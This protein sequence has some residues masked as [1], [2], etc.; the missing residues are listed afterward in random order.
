MNLAV[1]GHVEWV[2]FVRVARVPLPGEIVHAVE[3]W[4]EAAGGG[5]IA[6]VQLAKLNGSAH[7]FTS[8]GDDELGRRSRSELEERGVTLHAAAAAVPQRR[9]FTYVDERGERTITV[10]GPKLLPSG[11][12]GS[13]PWEELARCDAVF[14]VS[15]DVAALRAARRSRSELEERGVTLHVAA[16]AVPQ[17]RAFT[18]VDD[19][20]ERTITV[21]G[22]KLLPSGDDGSLPWEELARCDAVF[23][24]SG[25]VAALRAARRSRV[26]VATARELATLKR[27]GE[28][29]DVLVGSGEDPGERFEPGELEPPPRTVVT[30][31]GALG[32][33]VRPGGPFRAA[34]LPGPVE[35]AY[36]CGDCFAAGLTYALAA[37]GSMEDAV[38]AGARCGAAV[39]TGRGAYAGQLGGGD[40]TL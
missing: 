24:V 17:R 15:G 40:F 11:D 2:E 5:A 26:L 23:F 7:L 38:E 39:L 13:L 3:T 18:Y 12:D 20:G 21:L 35:D 16:A 28:E 34:P 8:L 1:V 29:I 32:G 27:G 22:P 37:G 33:W 10:L 14:F 25:D 9:A 30:T 4:E 19:R 6:A 31:S 36:G